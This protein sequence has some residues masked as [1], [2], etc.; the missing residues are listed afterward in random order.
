MTTHTTPDAATL[1]RAFAQRDAAT[2]TSLYAD[3]ATVE[4]VDTV[5]TPSR[6]HRLTGKDEI[7]AHLEDVLSRDMTH[8]VD[9][10]AASPTALGYSL[11]C[12]YADGMKVVC[13]ASAELRDGRIVREV[14]AQAWDAA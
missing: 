12:T 2:L 10:V 8:A 9:I 4:L 1:R 5:N 14:G 3:D 6:P 11:R 7:R 13:V